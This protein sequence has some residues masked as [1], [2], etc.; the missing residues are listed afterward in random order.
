MKLINDPVWQCGSVCGHF[1]ICRRD[2][3]TFFWNMRKWDFQLRERRGH[4][5]TKKEDDMKTVGE[6]HEETFGMMI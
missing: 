6:N 5:G 3:R 2:L 4:G 1:D